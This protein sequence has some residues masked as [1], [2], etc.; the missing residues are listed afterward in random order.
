MPKVPEQLGPLKL[1]EQIGVGRQCQIWAALET[2]AAGQS[3]RK[4]A[5]KVVVPD[6][7]GDAE[8][9]KL[10][11]HELKVA[12]ACDHPGVIKIDRLA[13][14][15][16]LAFLVMEIFP[17][18]NLK[19]QLAQGVDALA[20]KV[21]RIM[22]ELSLAVDH[23]HARGWVHRDLKP[24]NVLA[25]DDGRVKL[26]DLAIASPMPGVL[27]R[28]LGG[29]SKPQGSP[30]YMSPEQIRGQSVDGRSDIYSL[31]CLF[32]EMLSGKPPFASPNQNDLLNKHVS[33]PPPAVESVNKNVTTAMSKFLRDM[34]AKKPGDRPASMK[35]VQKTLR[36]IRVFERVA[37]IPPQKRG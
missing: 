17:H 11:E 29:G 19:K 5:V 25:A 34:L 35:E 14:A 31:G 36:S 20:P 15:S 22:T 3:P 10:L 16:G 27:G 6:A 28:L 24:E 30:S 8:Q 37:A 7:T 1:V 18:P 33:S 4:C 2:P 32:F 26:I 23:L 9:R 12:K 21:S 13:E